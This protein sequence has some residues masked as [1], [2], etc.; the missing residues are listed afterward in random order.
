MNDHKGTRSHANDCGQSRDPEYINRNLAMSRWCRFVR[1]V[2]AGCSED[3]REEM[4][5]RK[6]SRARRL[7]ADFNEVGTPTTVGYGPSWR[8]YTVAARRRARDATYVAVIDDRSANAS[9][10]ASAAVGGLATNSQT[11]KLKSRVLR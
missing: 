3:S 8:S 9:Y 6:L 5:N 4:T 7:V 10:C 2:N 1:T 11:L